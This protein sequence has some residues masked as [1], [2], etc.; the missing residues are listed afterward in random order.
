ML[1]TQHTRIHCLQPALALRCMGL[2]HSL[3]GLASWMTAACRSGSDCMSWTQRR[4]LNG[5][6]YAKVCCLEKVACCRHLWSA[7]RPRMVLRSTKSLIVEFRL[8]CSEDSHTHKT[9]EASAGSPRGR[10]SKACLLSLMQRVG[11]ARNSSIVGL[12]RPRPLRPKVA[13]RSKYGSLLWYLPHFGC[14][15]R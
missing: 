1:L 3:L 11:K 14:S 13:R 10:P 5:M 4:W 2:W 8:R 15:L 12:R 6:V 7:I 9:H